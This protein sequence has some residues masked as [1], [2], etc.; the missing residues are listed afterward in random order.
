ML[1]AHEPEDDLRKTAKSYI[2]K[3]ARDQKTFGIFYFCC[4]FNIFLAN[5]NQQ[6]LVETMLPRLIHLLVHHPDFSNELE[7]L[8][9]FSTYFIY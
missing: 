8:N 6:V 2:S 4:C 1:A 9:M 5:T 7:D 3:K